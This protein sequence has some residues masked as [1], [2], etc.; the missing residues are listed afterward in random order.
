MEKKAI[1][2]IYSS[3]LATCPALFVAA[4]VM[5]MTGGVPA[6]TVALLSASLILIAV[7]VPP[8]CQGWARKRQ[9]ALDIEKHFML[10]SLVVWG[11]WAVIF[12]II[13]VP[14][15]VGSD[16]GEGGKMS[17][18]SCAGQAFVLLLAALP[19]VLI[20]KPWGMAVRWLFKKMDISME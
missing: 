10:C 19:V 9:A 20:A 7:I 15:C 11:G 13:M 1:S 16:N 3:I 2:Q 12:A 18:E 14:V 6:W 17:F 5:L 8:I 4:N